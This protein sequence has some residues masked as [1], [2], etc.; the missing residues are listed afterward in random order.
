MGASEI[1][2]ELGAPGDFGFSDVKKPAGY[3]HTFRDLAGPEHVTMMEELVASMGRSIESLL[4]GNKLSAKVSV[5]FHYPVR[6]Q[7][8]TLHLQLRI[9]SGNICGSENR[10]IDLFGLLTRMR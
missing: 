9:N 4:G 2:P 7:Y 5:G 1:L 10:G 3:L 8:S 6:S